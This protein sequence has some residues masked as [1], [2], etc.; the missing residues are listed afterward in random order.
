MFNRFAQA[1]MLGHSPSVADSMTSVYKGSKTSTSTTVSTPYQK[2]QYETLL[3]GSDSWL[4][5]GGFDKN[6]GGV[7]G[8]DNVAGFTDEQKA[9]LQGVQSQSGELANIY[10][11][12]GIKSLTD[13]LGSYDPS[14]TGVLEAMKAANEQSQFDFE[15]GQMG[16]IRQGA[17]EA[18]QYGSTR[19]GIAEGLAR[20]RLAQGQNAVNANLAYQDQQAW[21]NNRQNTLNNLSGITQ[22]LT[23]GLQSQFNAGQANQ[24]QQQS[25]IQ[26][27]LDKWAYENNVNLNDL[28]A[29]KTLISGDMGGT[30]TTTQKSSGGGNGL[31]GTLGTIGGAAAGAYFSGGNPAMMSAGAQLGGSLGGA[32]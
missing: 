2:K 16:N 31:L 18:G 10:N 1:L 14:K 7:E 24:Q 13:S 23:S 17:T 32:G 21:N 26:G 30:N 28:M 12:E 22:G 6:F 5:G 11:T 8:F 15:T 29:Y 25:E 9:A 3:K 27:Q 19:A 20:G 4:K